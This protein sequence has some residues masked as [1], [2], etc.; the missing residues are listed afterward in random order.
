MHGGDNFKVADA[1]QAKNINTFRNARLK[2][3]KPKAAI[4]LKKS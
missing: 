4:W 3:L 1:K 2:L